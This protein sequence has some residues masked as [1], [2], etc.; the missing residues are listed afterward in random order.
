MEKKNKKLDRAQQKY[1][2]DRPLQ[3]NGLSLLK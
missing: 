3:Y 1:N 2:F